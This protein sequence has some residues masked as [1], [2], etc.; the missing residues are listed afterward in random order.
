MDYD[1]FSQMVL[2]AHLKPLKKG[3]AESI[4]RHQQDT[5]LNFVAVYSQI[6]PEHKVV[7]GFDEEIVRKLL[8]LNLEEQLRAPTSQ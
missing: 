5:P 2:G 8:Q 6:G 1:G 3:E 7:P 4:F